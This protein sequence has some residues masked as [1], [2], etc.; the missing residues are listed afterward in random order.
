M[1]KS[2]YKL[3]IIVYTWR[4]GAAVS[5]LVKEAEV[6]EAIKRRQDRF[7]VVAKDEPKVSFKTC[8][9]QD[10]LKKYHNYS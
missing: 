7:G 4:F 1:N 10:R 6:S 8:P 5:P 2:W 9:R 3:I